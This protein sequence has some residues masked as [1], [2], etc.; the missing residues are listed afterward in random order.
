LSWFVKLILRFVPAAWRKT[1]AITAFS[2]KGSIAPALHV[3]SCGRLEPTSQRSII[4]FAHWEGRRFH[5]VG[6]AKS[7][8][9]TGE[10]P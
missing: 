1:E 6:R 8:R 7:R 3:E 9:N 4:E 5:G 10:P 2:R